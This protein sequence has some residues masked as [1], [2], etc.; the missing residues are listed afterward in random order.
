MVKVLLIREV[1]KLGVPG[2][3]VEVKG[4]YAR[5]Y[6]L[7]KHLAV[8]PTTHE[9]A[10]YTKLRE[11]YRHELADR[12]T[13]AE[14]LCEKLEDAELVFSR[15]VHDKDKLYATVRPQD[16]AKEIEERF[17]EKISPERINMDT[18][19]ALGEYSARVNI[20]EDITA[21]VKIT[22]NSTS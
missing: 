6:L 4:G 13:R 7:P 18:I 14:I 1:P 21:E 2:D 5:N 3:V 8:P 19:E 10:R 16:V 20:Y 12:R 11:Q 22:V 17:G 15:R 9:M